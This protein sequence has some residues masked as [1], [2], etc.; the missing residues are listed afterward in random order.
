MDIIFI[1]IQGSGKGTQ[2][3]LLQEKK[4]Y[5]LFETG[6]QLR[7]ISQEN[8]VLG[9]KI[10]KIIEN[11]NLVENETVM[12]LVETFLESHN[13]SQPILFDGIPR[14]ETQRQSL[15]TLLNNQNRLF[16]VIHITLPESEVLK[17]LH[18]RAE[19]EGR[20]DDTKEAIQTRIQ[21]FYTYTQPLIDTWK[22]ENKITTI[23]GDRPLQD[24]HTDIL[25][26][27]NSL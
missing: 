8:S 11:G 23:N 6:A 4:G 7:S 26:L 15:E 5:A 21:H 17:R 25:S 27:I 3:R 16:H 10:K 1:G 2:A 13:A 14:F 24:V 9:K 20:K 22:K 12:A 18:E 19:K